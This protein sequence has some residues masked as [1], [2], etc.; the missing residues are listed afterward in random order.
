VIFELTGIGLPYGNDAALIY[1]NALNVRVQFEGDT[2]YNQAYVHIADADTGLK[3]K[4]ESLQPGETRDITVSIS[5]DFAYQGDDPA[6]VSQQIRW[7]FTAITG[8]DAQTQVVS[9]PR[10]I[11][12]WVEIVC[13]TAGILVIVT[14]AAGVAR[15]FWKKTQKK[16]SADRGMPLGKI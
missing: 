11:P 2:V 14:A 12:R 8:K 15:A 5:C 4:T 9:Q 3:I 10:L 16:K 1:L 7:T 13:I 6:A